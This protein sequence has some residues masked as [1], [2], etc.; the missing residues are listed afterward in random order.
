MIGRHLTR[1]KEIG[2]RA[3]RPNI[4]LCPDDHACR[5]RC[6]GSG[7]CKA[8]RIEFA[9]DYPCVVE[10]SGE[11]SCLSATNDLLLIRPS[12]F[13]AGL[14]WLGLGSLGSGAAPAYHA[15]RA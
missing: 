9:G 12:R 3:H 2:C 13:L 5:V 15:Y 14:A 10:C 4:L 8:S 7:S 11:E 1:L 6:S